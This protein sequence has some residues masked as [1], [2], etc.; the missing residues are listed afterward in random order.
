MQDIWNHIRSLVP[1]GDAARAACVS[2]DFLRSWRCH[3]NLTLTVPSLGYSDFTRKV[4]HIL[5]KHSG[6][7]VKKL[8]LDYIECYDANTSNQLDGW[9]QLIVT[10]QNEELSLRVWSAKSWFPDDNY[11]FVLKYEFP[12]SVL[13]DGSRSSIRYLDLE[14]CVFRPTVQLGRLGFL[15]RLHLHCVNMTRDEL[16]CF[17]SNSLYPASLVT[18]PICRCME[19]TC[20]KR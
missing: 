4:D 16:E 7:G 14:G 19:A 15:A 11:S 5:E 12:C 8:V 3:P 20:C 9:L 2:S 6:V 18:S 1:L 17:L 13:S 10:P